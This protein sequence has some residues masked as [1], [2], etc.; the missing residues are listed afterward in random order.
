MKNANVL[1]LFFISTVL[2]SACSSLGQ[3]G[4]TAYTEEE[5]QKNVALRS[6]TI[7]MCR[8]NTL[9]NDIGTENCRLAFLVE[10]NENQKNT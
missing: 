4:E 10:K 9:I 2:C 5:L 1:L 8:K 6:E 3:G 7:D